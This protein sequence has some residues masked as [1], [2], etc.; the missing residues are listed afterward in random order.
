MSAFTP[1]AT[2]YGHNLFVRIVPQADFD[3]G[4][5]AIRDPYEGRNIKV[6]TVRHETT[7]QRL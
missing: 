6:I 3:L 1:I 5:A 2:E 4:S 7:Q